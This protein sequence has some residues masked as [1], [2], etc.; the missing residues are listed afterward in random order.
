MG[1]IMKTTQKILQACIILTL[2]LGLFTPTAVTTSP[3]QP[4]MSALLAQMV[5]ED[6]EQT[7]RVI[8]KRADDSDRAER[9]VEDMD[10]RV[11]KDLPMLDAFA[12]RMP[13]K[14]V[15]KLAVMASVN[16]V[17]LD[18]PIRPTANPIK[19]PE[20]PVEPLP[21]NVFLDT[22]G[23]RQ[24]WDMG[25][26][27]EGI[28]VV[29]IDS[30]IFTDRDFTITPGKP[31]T[32]IVV[33]ISFN[34]DTVSDEYGHGTHVAGI[35]GG[36]SGAS[37]GMYSGIAP[38][39][40]LI[41]L[42][43]SD[44][45]GL[46]Y[47][48]DTVNAMQWVLDHKDEYNIR[49]LNLSI[50]STVPQSYHDSALDAAA[51]ILWFNGVVV[52]AASG[53]FNDGDTYNAIQTA[54]ANDPF[55]I[56]VGAT[57]EKGT[58]ERMDDSITSFTSFGTTLEGYYKPD[59]FAPGVDI[60]SVLSWGSDWRFEHPERVVMDGEYFRLSGTSMAAPMVVGTAALLLQ[61]EPNLTPDQVKYRLTHA[62]GEVANN[63]YLDVYTALTT[64]TTESANQ[65]L[66]PHMLL[67]KMALIAY[68]ANEI[69]SE[70]ID[71][72]TVDWGAVNWD[73][74]NWNAVN[75]DA[76]NWDAVNWNAVNWNAVNWNAVNWNA[77]NWN[78]V[79][80]NAVNWNAVNW[81]AVNWNAVN[82]NAVSWEE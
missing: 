29:V 23:V 9:F 53:N 16:W 43:I 31:H 34:S 55:I 68:W 58:S 26:H 30:G 8:V 37:G 44:D 51:E 45:Y 57:D 47:E 33:Q 7:M 39:V 74:V 77:V 21:E 75:W 54:P 70:N 20:P 60:I 12:A 5:A 27:G 67:A 2:T 35:I 3:A 14:S 19:D 82:W 69:G 13:A 22:L 18:A 52:V 4:R 48:S 41:N 63:P 50:Q 78:A 1:K 24:V 59:I 80:W 61:A 38:K 66:I 56:T 65:D 15:P 49:V 73:A 36:N 11:L 81:N 32:R 42:K 71:W 72:D 25:Y 46:A 79:N 6:S 28:G 64:P 62:A 10:G 17:Y 40:D 76:V